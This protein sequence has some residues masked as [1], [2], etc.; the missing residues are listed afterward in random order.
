MEKD[1]DQATSKRMWGGRFSGDTDALVEVFGASIEVD[2]RMALEDIEGS[3]AHASMLMAQNILSE[4]ECDLICKGLRA[5]RDD[6]IAEKFVWNTALED[7]HM[8]IEHE[9][10]RRIGPIGGKLHTARSRNDQVSTDLR[11]WL[12]R[13][14]ERI[15]LELYTFRS[16]LVKIAQSHLNV[17][18]PGYTHLQV[19]QPVLFSHHIMA[20]YSMF[21]RDAERLSQA[22]KRMNVSPLGS[23]ALAGT[24]FNIDRG[25]TASKLGFDGVAMNSMDAV[26]DR[27]FV[28]DYLSVFSILMIHLSRLSEEFILWSSQEFGFISLPDSHATGSS[29]MPQKKN[30]DMCE[31]IRGKAGRVCGN[32]MALLMTMKGL[33]LSYNKD[34]QEDKEGVFDAVDTVEMS[35]QIYSSMLSGIKVNA[36]RMRQAAESGFSNATDLADYLST[37]GMPFREAHEVVGRLVAI[38][39]SEGITLESLSIQQMQEVSSLIEDD[40]K[41]YLTL[42]AVVGARRSAGGTAPKEVKNQIAFAIRELS[43]EAEI[44][45]PAQTQSF[46]H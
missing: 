42:D 38:C 13:A 45:T 36:D 39:L 32:F 21:S 3:L 16:E 35:L 28:L 22:Q 18:M 27:D 25:E 6:I 14:S 44:L 30:P 7:V 1:F 4:Q 43:S 40:I 17:V 12:R 20:Y 31:L 11:L 34:M 15:A 2:K 9:L 5:I 8:N 33:P 26:S 29:I 24:G 19:A 23:C 37:K 41:D 46:V 10:T